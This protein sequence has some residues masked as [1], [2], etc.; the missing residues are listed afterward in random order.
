MNIG[1]LHT[2]EKTLS[3]MEHVN[4]TQKSQSWIVNL[5]PSCYLNTG[6][7]TAPPCHGIPLYMLLYFEKFILFF[8]RSCRVWNYNVFVLVLFLF[9]ADEFF[10]HRFLFSFIKSSVWVSK[11]LVCFIHMFLF[12]FFFF[13][14]G[15]GYSQS[16]GVRLWWWDILWLSGCCES[17]CKYW[18][19]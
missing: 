14:L 6:L 17:K 12:L 9:H 5:R 4:C 19:V 3:Y 18:S 10:P 15:G 1:Y 7:I 16:K 13:C 2:Q 11:S 8:R